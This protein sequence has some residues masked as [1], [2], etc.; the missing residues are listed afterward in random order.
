MFLYIDFMTNADGNTANDTM[1]NYIIVDEST[2]AKDYTDIDGNINTHIGSTTV[3]LKMGQ[4]FDIFLAD[5]VSSVTFYLGGAHVGDTV[6]ASVYGVSSGLPNFAL[7]TTANHIITTADTSNFVNLSF[8]PGIAVGTGSFAIVLN[9]VSTTHNIALGFDNNIYTPNTTFYK[10]G[11]GAWALLDTGSFYKGAFVLRPNL[12]AVSCNLGV[13]ANVTNA[14]CSSC[15]DGSATAIISNGFAPY[16]YTWFTAPIQNAQTATSL[17]PGTYTVCAT[18]GAGCTA[19]NYSITVSSGC[20]AYYYL[21]ADTN[22]H[23]YYLVNMSSGT[24]PLTYDWNW[25]DGSPHDTAAFPAHTY[26]GQGNYTICLSITDATSCTNSYC[27]AFYL[28]G[29]M[30]SSA[31]G[32]QVI[33]PVTSG[34]QA[35]SNVKIFSVYPNPTS[36]DLILRLSENAEVNIY[37]VLGE[38]KF[39]SFIKENETHLNLSSLSSG[40]YF[41]K[42]TNENGVRVKRF[43]KE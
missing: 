24:P 37:N 30:S 17:S 34:V 35:N 32:V 12:G 38:T 43:I 11:A 19:C 2:Y 3:S 1:L 10:A 26:A 9:Q 27:S 25:G 20:T 13:T 23:S 14:S 7:G 28:L 15:N 31:V 39:H 18:D 41:I 5:T 22:P 8:S 36:G 21:Y 42:V 4:A 6:T 33:P 16:T 40:I 29:P